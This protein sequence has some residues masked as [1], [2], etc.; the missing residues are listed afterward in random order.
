MDVLVLLLVQLDI[1]VIQ[2]PT[3]VK[4]VKI[5]V[6]LVIMLPNVPPVTLVYSST[7]PN[8]LLHVHKDTMETLLTIPA[9]FVTKVA[10]PATDQLIPNVCLVITLDILVNPQSDIV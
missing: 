3:L 7:N 8:V 1:S 10:K 4:L 5:P 6:D 9:D 2:L